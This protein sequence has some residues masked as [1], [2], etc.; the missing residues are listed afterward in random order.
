MATLSLAAAEATAGVPEVQ[1]LVARKAGILD[2]LHHRARKALVN[3]AQDEAFGAYFTEHDHGAREKH[4][5]RI[6]QV[7]LAVQDRF[8]V[9]EMCLIDPNGHEISRIVGKDIAHDLSTEE[10]SNAFFAP[11]FEQR[12]RTVYVSPIYISQDVHKWVLA[13]ITPVV[14]D[15]T[16]KA[17]LHYEHGLDVFQA[18]VS[19]DMGATGPFVLAVSQE[20]YVVADS[21]RAIPVARQGEMEEQG[22]YFEEFAFGGMTRDE[23]LERL[24]SERGGTV[25]TAEGTFAVAARG[26]ENWTLLAFEQQ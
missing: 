22:A 10:A 6:D 11:A 20:G 15:G 17:I 25:T 23:L 4:K 12:P 13:Y 16:K 8:Q 7:S 3:A 18:I 1:A 9:E 14:V 5:H 2:L 24:G 21:R 19:R 26:A